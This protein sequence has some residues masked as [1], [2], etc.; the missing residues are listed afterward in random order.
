MLFQTVTLHEVLAV[1]VIKT[2]IVLLLLTFLKPSTRPR[3]F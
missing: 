2:L 3:L 1:K